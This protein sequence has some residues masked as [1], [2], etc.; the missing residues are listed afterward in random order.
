MLGLYFHIP[1]C[2]KKCAY[3]DFVSTGQ[4]SK[5]APYMHALQKETEL[6]G[7]MYNKA[8]DS[9]FFGG[10]TP[11]L[12]DEDYIG[13]IMDTVRRL[14]KFREDAEV[15]LE[16]NPC[17]LTP[18]KLAAYQKAG[19]N[20]LSIGL[21]AAQ[22]QHLKTL[23]RQHTVAMFDEAFGMAREAGFENINVD[24]IYALPGQELAEWE[25]TLFHILHKKPE[26]VSAY[27]LKIEQGTPMARMVADGEI[28]PADEDTDVRMYHMAQA[29]LGNKGYTN[30]EISNFA[31]AGYE[32]AHNLKY[33]NL[34]DYIGLGV[35][36]HSCIERLRFA[37]TENIDGYIKNMGKGALRYEQSD[38]I[39]D[40]ERKVEYIMLKLRLK[41][42][43]LLYDYKSRFGEDF[44]L[45]HAQELKK[46]CSEGLCVVKDDCVMPTKRG[47][48]LQNRLVSI[49]IEHM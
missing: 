23:G 5:I 20:R 1:F 21:Q 30:Y 11:S 25:E 24:A 31:I 9:V 4:Q 33:W 22:D 18:G 40:T 37:N 42:G 28:T 19:I 34:K 13:R 38:F 39:D 26:H 12:I 3:C 6:I 35:S 44:L 2:I 16:A 29:I 10:G 46:A 48:D 32:C 45:T 47:F 41:K 49:L 15:T 7:G 36:A 17:S 27:A 43:F 8:V 14:F